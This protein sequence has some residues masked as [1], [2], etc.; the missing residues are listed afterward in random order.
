MIRAQIKYP[1]NSDEKNIEMFYVI[2]SMLRGHGFRHS[3]ASF[4]TLEDNGCGGGEIL[5]LNEEKAPTQSDLEKIFRELKIEGV[6]AKVG[7]GN[8]MLQRTL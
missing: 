4:Y 8:H 3:T 1:G 2:T 5:Y 7:R 6:E